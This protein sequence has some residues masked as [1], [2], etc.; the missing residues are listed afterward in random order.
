MASIG[1]GEDVE[2]QG[3][4]E[5]KAGEVILREAAAT[6]ASGLTAG[7]RRYDGVAGGSAEE[8]WVPIDWSR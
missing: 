4:P 7:V 2:D 3:L 8:A 6:K 5:I 1:T